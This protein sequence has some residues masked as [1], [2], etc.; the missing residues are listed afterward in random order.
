V[1]AC[2]AKAGKNKKAQ[3][4]GLRFARVCEIFD[5]GD[6]D[7]IMDAS[8]PD[9]VLIDRVC[10]G[11]TVAF[12]ELVR[13]YQSALRRV[14]RSRL[15]RA[16]WADD[17]VQ[18]TFLAAFKSCGSYD[19]RYSFRTWLWTILL[20]QCH[21]HYQRR[22]RGAT[23]EQWSSAGESAALEGAQ[24]YESSSP[25]GAL[26]AKE[27]SQQLERLLAQLTTVQADALRLRFFA[28]L[29]FQEIAE[30]MQCSLNTAKNRV[31]VGL[32]RMGEL[33]AST[34][35]TQHSSAKWEAE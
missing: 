4:T 20:N 22:A 19:P 12:A 32:V 16:D 24:Q 5:I 2:R 30:A 26:L 6:V 9:A 15:G 31:R 23:V 34:D 11:E 10:L 14:A 17:V 3:G 8:E 27:R 18:E 21:A 35:A 13:R 7:L 1:L 25:V 33:L 28:G 29:K